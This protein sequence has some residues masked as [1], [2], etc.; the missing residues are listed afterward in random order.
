MTISVFDLFSVGIGPS[1]SHTV[2]P[3]L[4]AKA[5]LKQLEQHNYL[6]SVKKLRIEL[7]GSLALTGMGHATDT[8]IL[9]GLEGHDPE[10]VDPESLIPRKQKI[11]TQQQ[12]MLSGRY[13]IRFVVKE[14]LVWLQK[15]VLPKHS[16]GMRFIAYDTHQK[17]VLEQVYYS[18]GGGFIVTAEEYDQVP[19]LLRRM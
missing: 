15:Q 18:I 16:N 7:Y 5:F 4:A 19:D 13:S 11:I 6:T 10:H 17:I 14:D 2:G 12:L 8:A 9:N 1:S 3:M